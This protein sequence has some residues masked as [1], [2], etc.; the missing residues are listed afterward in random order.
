[1]CE[2]WET[3]KMYSNGSVEIDGEF[4][5]TVELRVWKTM[6]GNAKIATFRKASEAGCRWLVITDHDE[7]IIIKRV[8]LPGEYNGKKNGRSASF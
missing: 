2:T 4:A 1:M 6:K 8:R 3:L 5:P 7:M